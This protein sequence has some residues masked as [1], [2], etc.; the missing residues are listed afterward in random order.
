MDEF[1]ERPAEG[2]LVAAEDASS[3]RSSPEPGTR[4]REPI[5]AIVIP[6]IR[7]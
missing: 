6:A 4:E 5:V 2:R 3:K 7:T 1:A